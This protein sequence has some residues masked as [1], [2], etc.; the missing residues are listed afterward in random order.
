MLLGPDRGSILLGAVFL[1]IL[2]AVNFRLDELIFRSK[3][4]PA[5]ERPSTAT[6]RKGKCFEQ[7]SD[8]ELRSPVSTG[9]QAQPK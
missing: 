8:E 9:D 4:K 5:R 2:L 3:K 7:Y 1:L 6:V